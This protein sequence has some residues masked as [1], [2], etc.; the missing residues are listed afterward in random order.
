MKSTPSLSDVAQL[1]HVS[2]ATVSRVLNYPQRTSL[3]TQQKV[4]K[5]IE[6]L[7]YQHYSRLTPYKTALPTQR[8]LIIDNQLISPS[9]INFG[10]E[11]EAYQ[12]GYQLCY[13]RLIGYRD[14]NLQQLL[15]QLVKYQVDGWIMI[16]HAPFLDLLKP[17]AP[18]LPPVIVVND[19]QPHLPCLYFDHLSISYQAIRY[20]IEQGH[21]KIAILVSHHQ[22]K[23]TQYIRQGYQLALQRTDLHYQRIISDCVTYQQAYQ[24]TKQLLTSPQRPSALVCFDQLHLIANQAT[25]AQLSQAATDN[26]S[27]FY[28]RSR[29]ILDACYALNLAIPQQLSVMTISYQQQ[30]ITTGEMPLT[31]LYKP[32]FSMGR[33]ALQLLL[34][35][36]TEPHQRVS[37]KIMLPEWKIHQSVAPPAH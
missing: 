20:L 23:E 11:A 6:Q 30:Q 22:A 31:A 2:T 24:A 5:A 3:R 29:A 34:Q 18:L 1:A 33:Q 10:L 36:L 26:P 14:N 8:L 4:H 12:H 7:N 27:H 15:R 17:I 28:S 32:L 9:A 19:Y 25:R 37:S 13:L 16:N 35:Q 21:Q